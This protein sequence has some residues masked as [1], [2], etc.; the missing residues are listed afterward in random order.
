MPIKTHQTL[1]AAVGEM[2]F[3]LGLALTQWQ[4]VEY[5]LYHL[6]IDLCGR[7]DEAALNAIFHE[8]SLETKMKSITELVRLRNKD[9]LSD[10]DKVSKA[11]FKQKRLRDKL[12]HWSVV[13]APRGDAYI[14]YLAPPV[15]DARA[16]KYIENP[17]G[18]AIDAETLRETSVR[19]FSFVAA[20]IQNF[21]K[22]M[23]P[24]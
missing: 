3:T 23:R 12:A 1:D 13:T 21:R 17:E 16:K 14:S 9:K 18:G 8:M 11:L 7:S 22:A 24:S 6:F 5:M 15:T 20:S 10:W 19:D 4:S 2:T